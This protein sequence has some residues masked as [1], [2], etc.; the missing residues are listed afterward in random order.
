MPMSPSLLQYAWWR[1]DQ[2]VV[3]LLSL[4]FVIL[5][6]KRARPSYLLQDLGLDLQDLVTFFSC[7]HVRKHTSC[8][9][10]P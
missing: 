2:N 7:P 8:K 6:A 5:Q 4:Y 9:Q 3:S 10:I 1:S